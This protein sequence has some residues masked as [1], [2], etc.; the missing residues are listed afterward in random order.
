MLRG[1]PL[2]T[3]RYRI[4]VDENGLGPRLGPMLVTA[5]LARVTPEG[6]ALVGRKPRGKL[7]QRIGDSKA[8]V[9][10]GDVALGEAWARVLAERQH[11]GA[12]TFSAIDDLVHA[13][14]LDDKEELFRPCPKHVER[15]CWSDEGEAFEAE[16]GLLAQVRRDVDA[17]AKKGVDVM[18]VRSVIVCTRRLNDA[19]A[20]GRSRFI[21]DLHSMERLV[22]SMREGLDDDVLAVC[23]K[24]GGLG[25]YETAFGPLGGRLVTVLEEKRPRSAYW[26]PGVGELRFVQD[27]DAS[28][29]LVGLASLVG[30]WLREVLMARVSRHYRSS[31]PDLPDPSGYY[32]P[33]TERFIEAT[34][35]LR[36]SRKVPD[37]CFERTTRDG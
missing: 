10:H 14:A 22:L 4:G 6:H 7:E 16:E 19:L 21:V 25:R 24:V 17:L 29:R 34:R 32:D 30:K 27:A 23:G 36:R 8:L 31:Q 11:A 5:V 33:V 2:P 13:L 9:S 35:L 3:T 18:S 37:T 12:R 28:D 20:A 15:Q 26:F 1:M